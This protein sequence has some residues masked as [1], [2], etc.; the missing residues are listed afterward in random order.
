MDADVPG[1]GLHQSREP[2]G[3]P[4]EH[5]PVWRFLRGVYPE[6]PGV[7]AAGLRGLRQVLRGLAA[8]VP[9]GAEWREDP[10]R[11]WRAAPRA[12]PVHLSPQAHGA[13]G[14]DGRDANQQLGR[15]RCEGLPM[16][17]S[18]GKQRPGGLDTWPQFDGL[19]SRCHAQL[20]PSGARRPHRPLSRGATVWGRVRLHAPESAM[21]G[22]QRLKLQGHRAQ[23]RSGVVDHLGGPRHGQPSEVGEAGGLLRASVVAGLRDGVR[24]AQ[25]VPRE[26]VGAAVLATDAFGTKIA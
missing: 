10:R 11:A 26:R 1:G 18:A 4:R 23:Q 7:R 16:V 3:R 20:L 22:L 6:V 19:R 13:T 12:Q 15:G 17:R 14:T 25:G 24:A 21:H 5:Q 2:R 8:G 9:L